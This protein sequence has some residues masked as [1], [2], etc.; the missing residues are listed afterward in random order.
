M[1]L[2]VVGDRLDQRAREEHPG[3]RR[4][5]ADVA[6]RPR[7]AARATNSGGSSW[8]AVTAVVFCAVS[9]TSTVIPWHAGGRERLQVGLDPGAAARVG[10]R[11][12]QAP[13][14]GHA[15]PFAG[16]TRIRFD[17]CDL[18]PGEG[19][20]GRRPSLASADAA[21]PRDEATGYDRRDGRR[22]RR[23][24]TTCSQGEELAHLGDEPARE[25]RLAPLPDELDPRVRER[26]RGVDALY[27]HQ[28]EAWDA[29]APRRA[30]DR[31][32][33]HREREDAR[34]QPARPRR[35]RARAEEPRALPLPDEGARAGSVPHARR[36]TRI[37]RLRPAI[38]DGDTPS[39]AALADPQVGERDPHQP[40]HAPRRRAPAPRPLGR[41]AREPPLRRRRRGARLPRRLRLARRRTCCGGCAGS[42]AIYGAEPQFLLASAT[43]SNPGELARVAA[44]RRR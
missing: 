25:P 5:D 19:H 12:R 29:A 24:G 44:R 27:A 18:S 14:N 22:R 11:D 41:R 17:G 30:R 2:E 26:A 20:P 34:V 32:D 4:V 28:P 33:R 37:P 21:S 10:G 15:A 31:H 42:R 39:R 3:L 43:I 13:R 16:M 1:R 38:Y 9:A 40:G 8:I 7:R 6:R 35:A 23:S 36:A